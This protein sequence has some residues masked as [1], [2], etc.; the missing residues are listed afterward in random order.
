[1]QINSSQNLSMQG[2]KENDFTQV[3]NK[4][5]ADKE[6]ESAQEFESMFIQSML[7]EIRPVRDEES[8]FGGGL[9]EDMFYQMMDEAIA[10]EISKSSNN[11]GIAES[12]MKQNFGQ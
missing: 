4:R 10:K 11:F 3:L 1:M 9:G 8:L 12:V 7:K 6:L 5:G 2:L